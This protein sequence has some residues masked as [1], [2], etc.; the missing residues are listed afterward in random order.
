MQEVTKPIVNLKDLTREKL[1]IDDFIYVD[2]APKI[3]KEF[4]ETLIELS[5]RKSLASFAE[6]FYLNTDY[7]RSCKT[8]TPIKLSVLRKLSIH[9][10]KNGY[11]KFSLDN[12]ENYIKFMKGSTSGIK[13]RPKFPLNFA[14]IEG[15]RIISKLYHDGG[16]GRNRQPFY[17]NKNEILINEFCK[18]IKAVFG[19][20]TIRRYKDLKSIKVSLPRL[21]GDILSVAGCHIGDKVFDNPSPP[22]WI[23]S[24]DKNLIKEFI[25]SAMDDEGCVSTNGSVQFALATK[26]TPL[27]SES[28]KSSLLRLPKSERNELIRNLIKNKKQE[29]RSKILEFDKKLIEK[30]GIHT[31]DSRI[32]SCYFDKNQNI[33]LCWGF[34]ISSIENLI[35]FHKTICFKLKYKSQNLINYFK[36]RRYKLNIIVPLFNNNF[37]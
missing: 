21:L 9:L 19:N 27:L 22:N 6:A 29:F 33:M 18:D 10:V 5:P 11:H 15:I 13:I 3:K 28:V 24:S 16:I 25:R 32:V 36:N 12:L 37:H 2:L 34:T 14:S 23:I 26:I 20:I 30:L 7:L 8:R 31:N 17:S 35:K 1:G 4:F